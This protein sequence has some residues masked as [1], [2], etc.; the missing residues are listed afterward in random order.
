MTTSEEILRS[1]SKRNKADFYILRGDH[2]GV[3]LQLHGIYLISQMP[4]AAKSTTRGSAA[5]A[6]RTDPLRSKNNGRGK[7]TQARTGGGDDSTS[8]AP[9]QDANQ[10]STTTT[11]PS[12]MIDPGSNY[13]L[14]VHMTLSSDPTINRLLSIPPQLT[15][16][17]FHEVLQIAFGWANCHMHAFHV[18][19]IT[20]P[21]NPYPRPV[22][23]LQATL[24]DDP[25]LGFIMLP[26]SK[27][28]LDDVFSRRILSS[29]VLAHTELEG[30]VKPEM[31]MGLVYEYDMGDGWTH[32]ITLLGRADPGL[33]RSM[34]GPGA[35]PILCLG[36][37]GHPCAE[38]CG[39]AE[40]WE[41]LKE[42]FTKARKKDPDDLKN[43]YKKQCYNGDPKGL[44]PW[45]WDIL[46][47]NDGLGEME[48]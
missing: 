18:T 24:D 44:D 42:I 41:N 32:Q 25:D 15:F 12:G 8:A 20:D 1:L 38:D 28:T 27:Y 5:A 6:S 19:L 36:G 21:K 11:T 39:S 22:L 9:N 4:R 17:K 3:H 14:L 45:K 16:D 2:D 46:E 10:Q 29:D 13:L 33:N 31:E 47:V 35:P 34:G 37:E 7:S 30:K 48:V 43:W 26:E 23:D 40:G